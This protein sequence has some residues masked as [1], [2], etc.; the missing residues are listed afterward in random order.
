MT[1]ICVVF[2]AETKAGAMAADSCWSGAHLSRSNPKIRRIGP[3]LVAS[4][5]AVAHLFL[6]QF[7]DALGDVG[8][9]G[10]PG[11]V[12]ALASD[13][14]R[15]CVDRGHHRLN[16]AH[17]LRQYPACLLILTPDGIFEIDDDGEAC[18]LPPE[19]T[20]A[21]IGIGAQVCMGAMHALS[22]PLGDLSADV[23]TM[24]A[25]EAAI[26]LCEGCRGPVQVEPLEAPEAVEPEVISVA[27]LVTLIEAD[28]IDRAFKLCGQAGGPLAMAC[29]SML[30][31]GANDA[32]MIEIVHADKVDDLP[33][34]EADLT[35][36]R[37]ALLERVR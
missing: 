18:R 11:D 28:N 15:W 27:V 17:G 4:A 32:D 3:A 12:R 31:Y 13:W 30:R 20:T 21:A 19:T 5:G 22:D 36:V 9:I 33:E 24:R 29:Q 8:S 6:D 16:E 14:R 26:E 7:V 2:D 35:T 37:D 25:V 23:I 1:A 10:D 34:H